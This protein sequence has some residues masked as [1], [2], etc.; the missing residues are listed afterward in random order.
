MSSVKIDKDIPM[1]QDKLGRKPK[2][3]WMDMDVG[4]SFLLPGKSIH[5]AASLMVRWQERGGRRYSARTVP[6]GVRIWRIE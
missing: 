2:Y 5:H 3:P 1:P 4:D 6:E